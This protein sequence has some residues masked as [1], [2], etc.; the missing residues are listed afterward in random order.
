MTSRPTRDAGIR[1]GELNGTATR[2]D[3]TGIHFDDFQALDHPRGRQQGHQHR[4]LLHGL[5]AGSA[6]AI[7]GDANT[8]RPF[9]GINDSASVARQISTDF[10]IEFWFK[11]TQSFGTTCTSGGR[12]PGSSTPRSAAATTTSARHC[13]DGRSSPASAQPR[14]HDRLRHRGTT[15]EPGTTSSS[16]G[17]V[18]RRIRAVHRR[19]HVG[20][21]HRPT[22]LPSPPP[23][24][25]R[26]DG[27]PVRDETT[28]PE[29]WTRSPSTPPSSA[30]PPCLRTTPQRSRSVARDR[31]T[32]PRLRDA[33]WWVDRHQLVPLTKSPRLRVVGELLDGPAVAVG[34]G[35]VDEP[36]PGLVVDT[37]AS[38]PRAVRSARASSAA[39]TTTWR[40]CNEPGSC[41]LRPLP[42][43]I[44]QAEPGGVSWTKRMFSS[45]GL[46]VVD[47]PAQGVAVESAR[48]VR[49]H[50]PGG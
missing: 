50:R 20:H 40:A 9:D 39:P 2:A 41:R 22:R 44:E 26:S 42:K 32:P 24:S 27:Q 25:S 6:G 23:R 31:A 29:R 37:C 4:R 16:H 35:E 8:A 46:V 15:T 34:V 48:A 47:G 19:R 7:A 30:L 5:H 1:D 49:G 21:G 38:T 10:S 43:A 45:D 18:D 17:R 36:A 3:T 11:S 28:S 14:R 12:A 13:A 33:P